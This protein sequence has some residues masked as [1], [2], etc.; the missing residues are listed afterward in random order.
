M[1]EETIVK[2]L[3]DSLLGTKENIDQNL[4]A[5]YR[6]GDTVCN[7]EDPHLLLKFVG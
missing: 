2:A 3:V 5:S 1:A 7:E 6:N 4:I